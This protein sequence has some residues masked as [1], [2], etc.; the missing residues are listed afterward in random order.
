VSPYIRKVRTASRATAVQIAEKVAGVRR[1]VA[2]MS[3]PAHRRRAGGAAG[4][5]A[6]TAPRRPVGAGPERRGCSSAPEYSSGAQCAARR[7]VTP[8]SACVGSHIVEALGPAG[9]D[10]QP[11]ACSGQGAVRSAPSRAAVETSV[12]PCQY[13]PQALLSARSRAGSDSGRNLRHCVRGAP[14]RGV[15]AARVVAAQRLAAAA[16]GVQSRP[17]FCLGYRAN[18]GTAKD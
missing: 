9:L 4:D 2:R 16:I 1:I 7:L 14:C 5:R 18:K 12:V 8:P 3:G 17:S 13:T 15:Q 6:R 11:R 10:W